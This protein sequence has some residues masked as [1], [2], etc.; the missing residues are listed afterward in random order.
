MK[1]LEISLS[2]ELFFSQSNAMISLIRI[3]CDQ[4]FLVPLISSSKER[5]IVIRCCHIKL[6]C[7]FQ[8][9]L[10]KYT[11][12]RLYTGI[13]KRVILQTVKNQKKCSM[14]LHFIRSTL[15]VKAK[16]LHIEKNTI[17]FENH[18]LT[19]LNMYNG[20]Y[21]VYCIKPEGTIH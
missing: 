1:C 2:I 7:F 14:M 11:R 4:I 21:K 9:Y 18:N 12:S 8:Y 19:P 17:L 16:D 10:S 15:F 5:E 6:C 13:P 3:P 20:L